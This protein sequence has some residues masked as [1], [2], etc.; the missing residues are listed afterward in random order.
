MAIYSVN[1]IDNKTIKL[2]VRA[3]SAEAAQELVESWS[4]TDEAVFDSDG[5]ASPDECID[6][7]CISANFEIEE[8]IEEND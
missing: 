5:K 8:A 6:R 3:D 1:V 2:T 4:F 7:E